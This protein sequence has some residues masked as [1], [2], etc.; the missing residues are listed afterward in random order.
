MSRTLRTRRSPLPSPG[1]TAPAVVA[2]CFFVLALAFSAT[3]I[4]GAGQI[5]TAKLVVNNVYGDSLNK[6]IKRGEGVQSDQKIRTG[7]ES[8]TNIIFMDETT[9]TLGERSELVLDH[10]VYD[11]NRNAVGGVFR[12]VKGV[13]R[14]VSSSSADLELTFKTKFAQIGLRGTR[15]DVYATARATEMAVH[16]GQVQVDSQ[17]GTQVVETGQVLRVSDAQGAAFEAQPS[18]EMSQAVSKMLALTTEGAADAQASE[19]A[20][21]VAGKDPEN[22]LYLD[23]AHGRLVIELRPD[24]A[25]VHVARIKELARQR[26]YDGL[27]FHNV[28]AG[29][30]VE[31]G[32]PTGT[33]AGGS[34]KSLAAELSD[35]PFLRGVVGMKHARDAP[36]TADSQFFITLGPAPHLDGK[37]TVWGRVIHGMRLTDL[38]S[39]GS[40]PRDPDKIHSLRVAADAKD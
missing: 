37:Y 19:L 2:L 16:E 27:I 34:G 6:R 36:D 13:L 24:L 35:V 38:L 4:Q 1:Q 32:D 33:G 22:L 14:F 30:A 10:L 9:L 29:F 40:P 15:F 7:V 39:R 3:P 8:A 11:P 5:G 25:P 12:F 21:A 28:V 18:A 26:F 23:L 17:F 20:A 31:T